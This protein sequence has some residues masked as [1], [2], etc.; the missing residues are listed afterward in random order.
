MVKMKLNKCAYHSWNA[1]IK[2]GLFSLH[3][4]GML[5]W[6]LLLTHRKEEYEL[7]IVDLF[8]SF[9]TQKSNNN[10]TIV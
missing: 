6:N 3:D 5:R 10:F 2:L 4:I 7:A 9:Q 8:L 1:L